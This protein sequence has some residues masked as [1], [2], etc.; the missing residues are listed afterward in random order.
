MRREY[1]SDWM[2]RGLEVEIEAKVELELE[3]EVEY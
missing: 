1:T 3:V 2:I